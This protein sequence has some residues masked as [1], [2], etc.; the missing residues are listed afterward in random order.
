MATLVILIALSTALSG[1]TSWLERRL[2]ARG[3]RRTPARA[4]ASQR[5]QAPAIE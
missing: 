3:R 2:L 5:L 4:A 1:A